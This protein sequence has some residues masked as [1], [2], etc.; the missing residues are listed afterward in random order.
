MT[1]VSVSFTPFCLPSSPSPTR[2]GHLSRRLSI[3]PCRFAGL[4][5]AKSFDLTN[6]CA[7][8]SSISRHQPTSSS[9]KSKCTSIHVGRGALTRAIN[10]H[11]SLSF[12]HCKSSLAQQQTDFASFYQFSTSS[13][14]TRLV[15]RKRKGSEEGKKKRCV[16]PVNAPRAVSMY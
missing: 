1:T 3:R 13:R 5:L 10:H 6:R 11:T 9:E 16:L 8:A 2:Y 12:V 14:F 7:P 15:A 4:V